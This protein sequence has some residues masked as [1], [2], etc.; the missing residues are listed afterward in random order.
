M[1]DALGTWA[2]SAELRLDEVRRRHVCD[3]LC[4]D[5]Y[6]VPTTYR[7]RALPKIPCRC[8]EEGGSAVL[9]L[10]GVGAF[11]GS[12]VQGVGYNVAGFEG[13]RIRVEWC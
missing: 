12:M 10:A 8:L 2:E 4:A 7:L 3:L 5:P 11:G 13:Q 9:A 6:I 1:E